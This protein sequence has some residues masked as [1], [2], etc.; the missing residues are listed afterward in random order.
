MQV[1]NLQNFSD[2]FVM[3]RERD[4]TWFRKST[5]LGDCCREGRFQRGFQPSR[6][7]VQE[8]TGLVPYICSVTP[9]Y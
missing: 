7:L 1:N 3:F 8:D 2:V 5:K 9:R 6:E 4:D